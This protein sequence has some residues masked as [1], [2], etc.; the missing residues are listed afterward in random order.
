MTQK[1]RKRKISHICVSDGCFERALS[2]GLLCWEQEEYMNT[3]NDNEL[4]YYKRHRLRRGNRMMHCVL[5]FWLLGWSQ[6]FTA[7]LSLTGGH[8]AGGRTSWRKGQ[9]RRNSQWTAGWVKMFN[10]VKYPNYLFLPW[11]FGFVCCGFHYRF[12]L[13]WPGTQRCAGGKGGEGSRGPYRGAG[14]C[15][16]LARTRGIVLGCR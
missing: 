12:I 2:W 4:W 6:M 3:H 16:Y 9:Q 8:S 10:V 11:I 15:A 5:M 14:K 1:W 13:G 7:V